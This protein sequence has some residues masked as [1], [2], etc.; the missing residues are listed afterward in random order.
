MTGMKIPT[1]EVLGVRVSAIHLGQACSYLEQFVDQRERVYVCTSPV[2]TIMACHADERLRAIVNAA[3]LVTPDGMP[4]VWLGRLKG[5]K[6]MSRVYGPDLMLAL[7]ERSAARGFK[8][9]FFGATDAVLERLKYRMME[10]FPGLPVCGTWAPPFAE[11]TRE[12]SERIVR[13]INDACPD[14]LWVGLGSPKQDRWMAEHRPLLNVPVMVGVGA[15]FDF[16]SGAKPQA[17]LWMQRSGLEWLFRLCMEPRR[18]WKRYL[19]GNTQFIYHLAREW[20][21]RV[22]EK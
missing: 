2:S 18:L 3:R 16:L 17:P 11:T 14:I 8:N 13:A 1:F 5:F 6:D 19:V 4:S 9:Y 7:L 22:P 15:A 20:V 12:E 10:R 21:S